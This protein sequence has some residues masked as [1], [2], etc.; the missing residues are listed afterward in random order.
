MMNQDKALDVALALSKQGRF[1]Q[2]ESVL[3]ELPSDNIRAR[4][5][6][7]W[8][9]LANGQMQKGFEGLNMGRFIEVFG[10]PP[11]P[12]RIWRDE[13]L[14]G[15]TVLLRMEGGL[16]DEI[17]NFRF[18]R[19]FQ[20]KGAVVIICCSAS[21]APVF[22]AEGFACITEPAIPYTQYDYWVPAMSA[23]YVLGYEYQTLPGE[24]YMELTPPKVTG[25]RMKIGLRWGGNNA[26]RDVEPHR[27]VQASSMIELSRH[28]DAD[29]F[30]FQRD[31]D[32]MPVP[33]T[34][35]R[36]ELIDWK[37]T[38]AW[39]CSMDLLITSCTSVAHMAAAMGVPTWILTP[40]M[41]YYTWA[42][43]GKKSAWY[44]SVTLFRQTKPGCWKA[45]LEAIK[46]ELR[47]KL[48]EAA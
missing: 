45:P 30:S 19:D 20:K 43:P 2:A 26:N 10:S 5:N 1:K 37:A 39:L 40:I 32:L 33:F 47:T 24:P 16:G 11:I 29:F 6:L 28:I 8:Y 4:Y 38:R 14:T 22:A 46:S 18:A 31:A 23:A 48:Q 27:K 9:D 41:P 13:G 17:I 21:L 34:D 3:R 12:G 36:D 35:L 7:G 25:N 42:V 44:D 15:K